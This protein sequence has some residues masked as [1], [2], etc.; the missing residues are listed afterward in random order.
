MVG[1]DGAG[2]ATITAF[3]TYL[4]VTMG[5]GVPVVVELTTPLRVAPARPGRVAGPAHQEAER[6]AIGPTT[7]SGACKR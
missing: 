5:L 2:S 1:V 7:G 3:P 4:M 6:G